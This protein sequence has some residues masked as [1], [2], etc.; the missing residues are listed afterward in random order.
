MFTSMKSM[1]SV[2]DEIN[3]SKTLDATGRLCPDLIVD[4]DNYVNKLKHGQVLEVLS[5]DSATCR[6]VPVWCVDTGNVLLASVFNRKNYKYYYW[7]KRVR[8]NTDS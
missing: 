7:V 2:I 8:K 5:T 4:I 3:V 1:S 6:C